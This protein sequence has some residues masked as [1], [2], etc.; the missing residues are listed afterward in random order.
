MSGNFWRFPLAKTLVFDEQSKKLWQT[1]L[2]A[3]CM[4]NV[5][6]R[7]LVGAKSWF[8]PAQPVGNVCLDASDLI[9]AVYKLKMTEK[10]WLIYMKMVEWKWSNEWRCLVRSLLNCRTVWPRWAK[11]TN[12]IYVFSANN[13]RWL[14]SK[15]TCKINKT[16]LMKA[17]H[18]DG[19]WCAIHVRLSHPRPPSS[20]QFSRWTFIYRMLSFDAIRILNICNNQRKRQLK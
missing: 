8:R 13:G 11:I 4:G 14:K 10:H 7:F 17:H 1:I 20:A 12:Y 2:E 3:N 6:E 18:L 9:M 16:F 15:T 19:C 5:C